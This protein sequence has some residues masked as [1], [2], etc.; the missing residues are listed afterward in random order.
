MTQGSTKRA[1]AQAARAW[2]AAGFAATLAV[3]LALFPFVSGDTKG[4]M[5]P[6]TEFIREHGAWRSLAGDFSNYPPLYLYLLTLAAWLPLPPLYAIKTVSVVFDYVLAWYVSQIVGLEGGSRNRG[7]AA[8]LA[9]LFLPTVVMNSA[10]W[11]QC[12]AMY[13]SGV[14]ACV[15]Y[16]LRRQPVAAMVAW[17]V[18]WS[19]K[20]QAVF[21]SPLVLVLLLEGRF[22][23]LLLYLVPGVYLALAVPAWAAGRPFGDLVL[24]YAHQRILPFPC[25][26]LGATNIYQWLPG[27]PFDV[28]FPIGLGL[29]GL[30]ALGLVGVVWLRHRPRLDNPTVLRTALVSLVLMPYVLPAMHERYFFAADALAVAFA[31]WVRGGWGVA[32]LIQV[33]S[34]FTY[35][36]YLFGIEPVPRPLLAVVMGVAL[37]W[38]GWPLMRKRNEPNRAERGLTVKVS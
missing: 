11:G 12:D 36:P 19:F 24:M 14:V 23:P 21:L 32:V 37:V 7:R 31:F 35:L 10:L 29:A 38:C 3:R 1:R 5:I 30:C 34:A 4:D 17:G 8:M 25:L 2:F 16:L 28:F 6:W 15:Y 33:A 22:S 27:A 18:A 20:P 26:T 13:A 9:V